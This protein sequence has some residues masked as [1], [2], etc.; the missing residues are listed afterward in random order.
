[1]RKKTFPKG[2]KSVNTG[3]FFKLSEKTPHINGTLTGDDEVKGKFGKQRVWL[4]K[5][6][7]VIYRVNG[8]AGLDRQLDELK[9]GTMVYLTY[10]G[11]SK[12]EK[13]FWVKNIE[14]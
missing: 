3:N 5:N 2:K 9:V 14:V 10:K 13:G 7:G 11:K 1:M 12:T 8:S 4:I 6:N